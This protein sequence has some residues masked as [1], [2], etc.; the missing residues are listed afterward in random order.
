M[1]ISSG[2]GF[3]NV[4]SGPVEI[5]TAGFREAQKDLRI[6]F[7]YSRYKRNSG[8][9]S[10]YIKQKTSAFTTA[11]RYAAN[12]W[13]NSGSKFI[14]DYKGL[15]STSG[16]FGNG[17]NEIYW[18]NSDD[19]DGALA[20]TVYRLSGSSIIESDIEFNDSE[21]WST[22]PGGWQYDVES[23]A[24]HE[25][26]HCF[27]L[28]DLYGDVDSNYDYA[29]IMYGIGR[30][31]ET[32]RTLHTD[33]IAGVMYI[34]GKQGTSLTDGVAVTGISGS[35][36]SAKFYRITV[37]SGAAGVTFKTYGGSGNCNMYIRRSTLPTTTTYDH[38]AVTST[39]TETVYISYPT[40]GEYFIMLQGASSYSGMS[41]LAD[42]SMYITLTDGLTR[43]G[44]SGSTGNYKYFRI[45]VPAG[46]A[47]LR[48]KSSGGAGNCNLY[49]RKGALPTTSVYDRSSVTSTNAEGIGFNNPASGSWYILVHGASSYSGVSLLADY[50]IPITLANN[51][52]VTNIA[53]TPTSAKF[54]KIVVPAGRTRLTVKTYGGTGNCNLYVRK[55]YLPTLATY[56]SAPK[57]AAN[58][59]TIVINA[60][61]AGNYF[62]MVY[63]AAS[64]SGVSLKAYY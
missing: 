53:G 61:A 31:G 22:N 47:S 14:F 13:N 24:L 39:N 32:I 17:R 35:T 2:D 60:P 43:T 64:Y 46:A 36:S 30:P 4:S 18:S 8:V 62:M 15:Q 45:A 3:E 26:G 23:I 57:L 52:A 1:D 16:S 59:E 5:R 28:M 6:T 27:G 12:T 37:P 11:I 40:A 50:L 44:I 48:I 63:G 42:Y 54:Y 49:A 34:Y 10:Y 41:L 9:M 25:L 58:T 20:V 38:A 19:V 29:K 33:D 56:D 55:N 7:G 51:V 21:S